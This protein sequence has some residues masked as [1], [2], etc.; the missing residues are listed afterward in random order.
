MGHDSCGVLRSAGD[1][2]SAGSSVHQTVMVSR[3]QLQL[4]EKER[5]FSNKIDVIRIIFNSGCCTF[6]VRTR[7][8]G[9]AWEQD[10]LG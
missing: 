2:Q 9:E 8:A 5:S 4:E 10:G 3:Q 1:K 6:T 7:Q